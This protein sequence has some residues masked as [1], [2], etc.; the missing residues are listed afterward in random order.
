MPNRSEPVPTVV[1]VPVASVFGRF[2][3]IVAASGDYSV[4]M[5]TGAAPVASPTFTGTPAAPTAIAGSNTAQLATCEFVLA[6]AGA[7]SIGS[8]IGSGT[9]GS[10]LFLGASGALSQDNA[11]FKWNS[12][13]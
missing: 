9:Q 13:F 8:S 6:N 2:D 7:T 11:N 1:S 5:V 4:G 12:S 10:V 3:V